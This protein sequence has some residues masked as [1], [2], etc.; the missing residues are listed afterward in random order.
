MKQT[1][2]FRFR[3]IGGALTLAGLFVFIWM[4]RLLNNEDARKLVLEGQSIQTITEIVMPVRGSIY[5]TWGH[6]LAG[7]VEVYDIYAEVRNV[8]DADTIATT[9]AS[10]LGV[11]QSEIRDKMLEPRC[12]RNRTRNR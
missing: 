7:N 10:V 12:E 3:F 6:L 11:K 9:L 1:S 4:I 5:D 2:F 8:T